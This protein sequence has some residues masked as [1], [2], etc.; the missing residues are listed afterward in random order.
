MSGVGREC[1]GRCA[2]AVTESWPFACNRKPATANRWDMTAQIFDQ[3]R[4]AISSGKLWEVKVGTAAGQFL[5]TPRHAAERMAAIAERRM[6]QG[7]PITFSVYR[8]DRDDQREQDLSSDVANIFAVTGW[9]ASD[10]Q[11]QRA[12]VVEMLEAILAE[13]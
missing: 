1:A 13:L 4:T 2:K 5:S 8:L 3:H 6:I 10:C 12:L 7:R 11:L 9:P